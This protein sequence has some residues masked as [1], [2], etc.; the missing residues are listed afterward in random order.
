MLAAITLIAMSTERGR[1]AAHDGVEY[2]DL[3]VG[4]GLSIAI[5][6]SIAAPLNDIGHLPRWTVITLR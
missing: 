4:Q 3:W 5:Q 2:L 1:T 6:K